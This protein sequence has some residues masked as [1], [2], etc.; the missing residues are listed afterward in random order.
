MKIMIHSCDPFLLARMST[1]LQ[2]DGM[3]ADVGFGWEDP[4]DSLNVDGTPTEEKDRRKTEMCV[5]D[6]DEFTFY[7]EGLIKPDV[8]LWL[9]EENYQETHSYILANKDK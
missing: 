5:K 8:K 2:M 9:T 3:I 6:A 4:W 7:P 1:E